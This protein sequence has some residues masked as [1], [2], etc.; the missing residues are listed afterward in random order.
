MFKFVKTRD[1]DN[2]FDNTD[3]MVRVDTVDRAELFDAFK[4]FLLACGFVVNGE[5]DEVGNED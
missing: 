2:R 5:I 1:P 4:E 3:V